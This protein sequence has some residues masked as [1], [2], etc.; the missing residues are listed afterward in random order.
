MENAETREDQAQETRIAAEAETEQEQASPTP[1]QDKETPGTLVAEP[2]TQTEGAATQQ[3]V[4]C[5][6]CG[7]ANPLTAR[8]C[9][10]CS[11]LLPFRHTTGMLVGPT[12]LA[13]RYQLLSCIGQGG[14]GAV[15]KAAD[16]RFNNRPVAIKE[17]S[18]SGL[19]AARL[20]EAEEAFEREAHLLA[21]LL[22]P[23][24]PRIYE[25]FAEN[26]RSYLVMD[27]IDGQTLEDYLAKVGGKPLPIDQVMK[28]AEQL[29]DVL[30]Y[31]HSHQ[32]PI[33]FRDLKPA[34]VMISENGH[35][36]LIDF[37]I[38]RIFKPGKQHDTVALGSPG[39]AAPEQYGKAQSS[40]RSDIYSLGALLHHLL[41]GIDP[42]E[43]PFFFRPA[44]Q[45]NPAID[46]AL[47][48]L[49]QQMLSMDSDRRPASAQEVL[50]ALKGT[51]NSQSR[52]TSRP[53]TSTQDPLL[54]EAHALYTQKR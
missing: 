48:A 49:L 50:N 43:Q 13:N 18:T 47:D 41:T 52:S 1:N 37:G 32:P 26:D 38:A 28:W 7:A 35:I 46:P 33:V 45:V 19:P 29:C 6:T 5:D 25:H 15:Y 20:Q 30:N 54:D 2:Q 8:Y 51:I 40:P 36:Y 24:L 4:F 31:L 10:H 22:H 53:L 23:N 39:Y 42:S 34:N 12:L 14:M 11:A 16:T 9:Q 27:F 44:S 21:D 3:E 17:M